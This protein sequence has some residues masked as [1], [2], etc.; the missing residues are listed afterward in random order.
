MGETRVTTS[1]F[2]QGFGALSDKASREPVIITKHGG[3]SLALAA[4]EEPA[5]LKRRDR[6]VGLT[7][8]LPKEWVEAVHTAEVPAQFSDLDAEL[9]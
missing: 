7:S 1:E 6:G 4:V 5:R 9:E 8:E 3:D 2:Q